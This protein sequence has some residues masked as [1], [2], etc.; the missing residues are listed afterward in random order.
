LSINTN[1]IVR[2][3]NGY[4]RADFNGLEYVSKFSKVLNIG[5]AALEANLFSRHT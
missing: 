4:V 5:R 1:N 3:K 2:L